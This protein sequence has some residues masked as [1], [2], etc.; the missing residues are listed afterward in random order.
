MFKYIM[1]CIIRISNI[2]VEDSIF[3]VNYLVKLLPINFICIR[4]Y[5]YKETFSRMPFVNAPNRQ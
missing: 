2:S 4:V 3:S 1:T 5:S